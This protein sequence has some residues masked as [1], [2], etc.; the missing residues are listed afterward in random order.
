MRGRTTFWTVFVVALVALS[1]TG[2]IT[3][4]HGLSQAARD[5][6]ETLIEVQASANRLGTLEW[7]AQAR[8]NV[9][10]G[11]AAEVDATLPRM[12]G[13]LLGLLDDGEDIR[14]PLRAFDAYRP[15]V[16]KEYELRRVRDVPAAA[17]QE[18]IVQ[19]RYEDLRDALRRAAGANARAAD[20]S[21]RLAWIGSAAVILLSA[22]G[23]TG[24]LLALE[25]AARRRALAEEL[26]RDGLTGLPNRA[27]VEQ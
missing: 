18:L 13:R 15:A 21:E 20:R 2:G 26:L 8:R 16:R 14:A 11:V 3:V 4:L 27:L 1:A 22:L 6:Y 10:M 19:T 17:A 9:P 25:R 5:R 12:R 7:E 24:L 23:L